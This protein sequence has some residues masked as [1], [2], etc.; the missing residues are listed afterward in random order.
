MALKT[1]NKVTHFYRHFGPSETFGTTF[2][3][4]LRAGLMYEQT[5]FR[6]VGSWTVDGRRQF[7]NFYSRYVLLKEICRWIREVFVLVILEDASCVF[8]RLL[9]LYFIN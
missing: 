5:F 2:Q 8:L 9:N 6:G 1:H 7:A 4:Q 3:C